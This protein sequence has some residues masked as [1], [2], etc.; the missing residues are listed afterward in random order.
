MEKFHLFQCTLILY[1]TVLLFL[2][3][4]NFLFFIF[5]ACCKLL[6]Y[7]FCNCSLG[8]IKFFFLNWWIEFVFKNVYIPPNARWRYAWSR[9][10]RGI[11]NRRRRHLIMAG[12]TKKTNVLFFRSSKCML[13]L[14]LLVFLPETSH[15]HMGKNIPS[16]LIIETLIHVMRILNECRQMG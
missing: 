12:C 10:K 7:H 8:Q 6:N 5:F 2:F 11:N 4:L 9:L 3:F 13:V 14:V 15:Q 1:C 16:A